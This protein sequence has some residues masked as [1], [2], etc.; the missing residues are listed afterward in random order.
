MAGERRGSKGSDLEETLKE[1]FINLGYFVVRA[2][3]YRL[4]GEDVTEWLIPLSP[5][6][7]H[8]V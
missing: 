5:P 8:L 1:Y 7:R 3:P 4:D 2:I 6:A